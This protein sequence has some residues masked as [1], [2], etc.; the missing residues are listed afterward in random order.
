MKPDDM[1]MGENEVEHAIRLSPLSMVLTD[2]RLD[3]N[4]ITYVNSAFESLTLY[5]RRYAIGR[6]CRFLQG[7]ETDAADVQKLRTGLESAEEFEVVIT[8]HRAD[9][10]AFRNQLLVAPIHGSDGA[11][12]G[13]FG[14]QR[15]IPQTV[16][17][18]EQEDA[19]LGLLRELQHRVK[20]HLAMIV[21]MI[22]IQARQDV[23]E[24][25]LKAIGRRIEALSVLYDELLSGGNS[26]KI[27]TGAYL[28]RIASVVSSLEPRGAIRVNV[29]CDE[30][31]LPVD[32]AA[33]LGL[34]LSEFL[35]N[36]F[37]HAFKGRS[38][39]T[40]EVRFQ[41]TG[42]QGLRLSVEDDGIGLPEGSNWPFGAASIET[43][44]ERAEDHDGALD[45]TGD[46]GKPGVG[47]S[48]VVALTQSLEAELSVETLE[49]GTRVTVEV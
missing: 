48:I 41:R 3:D 33:R 19:T 25:S 23:T 36:T 12:T 44:R 27:E 8:N 34:L 9:G 4:P 15:E 21:S 37:E 22:R 6:N 30:V 14:L 43:Q 47:G 31:S 11:L 24:E 46:R 18:P 2:P 20:N 17:M 10:T 40:V 39:G 49:Q 29:E 45:T 5:S 38:T 42:A 26:E 7:E 35:T 13:F 16:G 32:Q 28:S 1:E